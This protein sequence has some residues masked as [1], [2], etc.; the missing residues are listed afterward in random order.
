M[1][2]SDIAGLDHIV[3]EMR[4]IVK[5]LLGDSLYKKVGVRDWM[6]VCIRATNSHAGPSCFSFSLL[7]S[8]CL[9]SRLVPKSQGASSSRGLPEPGRLT[10]HERSQ[11]RQELR[12][13]GAT[14]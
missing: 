1:R 14:V 7:I 8:Q 4:E 5:M 3:M 2:F 6:Y 12:F 10:W 11:G 9:F 13:S